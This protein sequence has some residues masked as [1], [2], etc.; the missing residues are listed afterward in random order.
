MKIDCV[1]SGGGVNAF[2]FIGALEAIEHRGL[3]IER[4]AGTSAG[5]IISALITAGYS[6]QELKEIMEDFP[7]EQLLDPPT[8]SK[9]PFLK[10]ILFY[11]QKG[12]YKGDRFEK[13]IATILAH[14]GL[15][16][17]ADVK[18]QALKVIVSDISQGKLVVIPDDLKRLYGMDPEGFSIATAVRISAGFPYFFMPKKLR[19]P[20]HQER[21]VVD[22]GLLSNFPLWVFREKNKDRRPVLRVTLSED[23]ENTKAYPIKNAFDMLQALFRTMQKAHDS[24]FIATSK[25]PHIIFLPVKDV[26]TTDISISTTKKQELMTLGREKA[27]TFLAHWP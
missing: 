4:T 6:N 14:K 25:E 21:Y 5:A 13:W 1:F 11:F 8:F 27:A 19:D 3:E 17:F 24:R 9:I 15:Y 2:A 26:Q 16:T 22:G 12:L 18:K 20:S 7:L 10:W 23:I